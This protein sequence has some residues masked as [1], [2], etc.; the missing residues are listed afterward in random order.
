M[1]TTLTLDDDVA[2]ELERLRRKEGKRFKALVNEALRRGLRAAPEG[3]PRSKFRT[4]AV[5]LG[6]C[7]LHDVDNIGE[8]LARFEGDAFK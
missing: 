5:S 7:K 4:R 3:R 1:R 6:E 2:A 8:V